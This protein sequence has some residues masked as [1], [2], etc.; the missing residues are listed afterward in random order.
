MLSAAV[1]TCAALCAGADFV[2]RYR[3]R[4]THRDLEKRPFQAPALQEERLELCKRISEGARGARDLLQHWSKAADES[5]LEW[6]VGSFLFG[7]C[8]SS[9]QDDPDFKDCVDSIQ[10]SIEAEAE[11]GAE[12]GAEAFENHYFVRT[13]MRCVSGV[14]AVVQRAVTS[15]CAVLM[16]RS[17]FSEM[18][19]DGAR[20]WQK[21]GGPGGGRP[22]IAFFH[23]LG[24]G[25]YPYLDF[26]ADVSEHFDVVAFE[27]DQLTL[28]GRSMTN[29][30]AAAAVCGVIGGASPGTLV[31]A[32]HSYGAAIASAVYK[33]SPDLVSGLVLM[34]PICF[35]M[36]RGEIQS[37]FFDAGAP[38]SQRL[39]A[40]NPTIQSAVRE[41]MVWHESE[42][43][44]QEA[45]DARFLVVLSRKDQLVPFERT[46]MHVE[47]HC[48][49]SAGEREVL[50]VDGRH[51]S[52]FSSQR[53]TAITRIVA[54]FGGGPTS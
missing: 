7:S 47:K 20:Y 2:A 51:G 8:A 18:M 14:Y 30:E 52:S 49:V 40:R 24:V 15:R 41:G 35:L 38:V 44:P 39:M 27:F 12:A 54:L 37:R 34:A 10:V 13:P 29:V 4:D 25:L 53:R 46:K 36:Y 1:A 22:T 48:G 26:L 11:A 45:R 16:R 33:R 50:C 23:G 43:W 42:L 32:G 3:S 17:G 6:F 5:G 9:L 31:L 19:R 28:S 21:R